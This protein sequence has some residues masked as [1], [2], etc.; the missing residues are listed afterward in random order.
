MFHKVLGRGAYGS[1]YQARDLHTNQIVAWKVANVAK[2]DEALRKEFQLLATVDD[3]NV[4]RV[5]HA[6]LPDSATA[7]IY[8]EYMSG[9]SLE[10]QA[11]IFR[12]HEVAI[13]NCVAQILDGLDALHRR[14]SIVHCDLKP[15]NVL[16][17]DGEVKLSD[18]GA[19]AFVST[20]EAPVAAPPPALKAPPPGDTQDHPFV[21]CD[22]GTST[23][24]T[25]NSLRGA[26]GTGICQSYSHGNE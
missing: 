4:V 21:C 13:R 19:S 17:R 7:T 2:A 10:E 23:T 20:K 12:L 18:F 15:G 3:P 16:I 5:L 22:T 9:G 26:P 11:R 6:E 8:M 24:K 25:Q 14:Y 1:V